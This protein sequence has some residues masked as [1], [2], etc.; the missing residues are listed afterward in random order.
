M[1]YTLKELESI[2]AHYSD[3]V[4]EF[5]KEKI[6]VKTYNF[7][8]E[9]YENSY[10]VDKFDWLIKTEHLTREDHDIDCISYEDNLGTENS[11][12][13]VTVT[14]SVD[15]ISENY[16]QITKEEFNVRLD[17]FLNKIKEL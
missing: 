8:K 5:E 2:I 12:D 15:Y 13:V 14:M 3:V 10:W 16:K 4:A 17:E 11:Y 7:I 9:L 1:K 6:A